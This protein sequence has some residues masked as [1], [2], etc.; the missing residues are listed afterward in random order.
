[1]HRIFYKLPLLFALCPAL[2]WASPF[3]VRY[4]VEADS[5]AL[6][7][8][9]SVTFIRLDDATPTYAVQG[10]PLPGDVLLRP[11]LQQ[12]AY[13]PP[14][15]FGWLLLTS[16]TLPSP[17]VAAT[18]MPGS[19]GVAW[20]GNPTRRW[21]AK[22]GQ[23]PCG[24]LF[25]APALG[26]QTGLEAGALQT[27][28]AGLYW[29]NAGQLPLGCEGLRLEA[30]LSSRIGLPTRWA[31]G[32]GTL[33]LQHVGQDD[34]LLGAALPEWPSIT[35]PTDGE[36]RLRL[37]LGQLPVPQRTA[38]IKEHTALPLDAQINLLTGQIEQASEGAH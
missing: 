4:G 8:G 14:E 25:G 19:P 9:A 13:R 10:L 34:S 37:L 23:A 32:F 27:M 1:M 33:V 12:V 11:A 16:T 2:G 17:A 38:F 26:A 6:I 31:T 36:T 5:G 20:Q 22:V 21:A 18:I 35:Y 15:E 7:E 30:G 28:L 29:L 3:V 24:A